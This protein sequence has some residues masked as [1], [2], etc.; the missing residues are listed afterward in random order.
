MCLHCAWRLRPLCIVPIEGR[1]CACRMK[2]TRGK[3]ARKKL[4]LWVDV[5]CIP[6]VRAVHAFA[7]PCLWCAC[8]F[9]HFILLVLACVASRH[10]IGS[11]L[12]AL[13]ACVSSYFAAFAGGLLA[14]LLHPPGCDRSV[15]GSA[16]N[17]CSCCRVQKQLYDRQACCCVLPMPGHTVHIL[18]AVRDAHEAARWGKQCV[19]CAEDFEQYVG[20]GATYDRHA[21]CCMQC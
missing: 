13:F 4:F 19:P 20:L 16:P 17:S 21:C 10:H 6:F 7:A 1:D 9:C 11:S 8:A 15:R 3:Y 12:R 2:H 18:C 14:Q 5:S